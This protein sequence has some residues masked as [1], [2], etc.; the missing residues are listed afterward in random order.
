VQHLLRRAVK[1]VYERGT[2]DEEGLAL[3]SVELLDSLPQAACDSEAGRDLGVAAGFR[4]DP[5]YVPQGVLPDDVDSRQWL[6]PV[7]AASL[8]TVS[9]WVGREPEGLVLA[10]RQDLI[11]GGKELEG[12]P[13]TTPFVLWL[14]W[15]GRQYR[16]KVAIT[17][18]QRAGPFPTSD[19]EVTVE[20]FT[21]TSWRF[22]P[23]DAETLVE[24]AQLL[25]IELGRETQL[26]ARKLERDNTDKVLR[27]VRLLA[28]SNARDVPRDAVWHREWLGTLARELAELLL[29]DEY[30]DSA[31]LKELEYRLARHTVDKIVDVVKYVARGRAKELAALL[32]HDE[33]EAPDNQ[34]TFRTKLS[35]DGK[36][37]SR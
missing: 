14:S 3:W 22:T 34:H 31:R 7:D 16:E 30:S 18:G 1:T 32:L 15:N 12:V 13:A 28:E 5:S 23:S 19:H 29:S 36:A 11:P 21:G 26:L 25:A 8:P 2:E 33:D 35:Q 20:T 27:I 6:I 17:P 4:L 10:D 24:E 37:G 9:L